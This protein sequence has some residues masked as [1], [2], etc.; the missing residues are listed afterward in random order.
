ML[1][2]CASVAHCAAVMA[3]HM[4]SQP[5]HPLALPCAG[6]LTAYCEQTSGALMQLGLEA[7]GLLEEE[8]ASLAA[9][10]VGVAHGLVTLLRATIHH[11][12]QG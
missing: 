6:E 11:A 5:R 12:G 1:A 7:C 4:Q 3:H 10:H 2:R 8:K 9:H